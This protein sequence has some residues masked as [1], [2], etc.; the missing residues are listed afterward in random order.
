MKTEYKQGEM[1][2]THDTGHVDRYNR[3]DLERQRELLEQ[4]RTETQ[5]KIAVINS[6]ISKINSSIGAN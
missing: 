3:L 6:D 1:I 5:N 4:D 2:I